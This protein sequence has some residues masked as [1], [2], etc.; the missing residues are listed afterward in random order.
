MTLT[1]ETQKP[2]NSRTKTHAQ[3]RTRAPLPLAMPER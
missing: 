2:R 3:T 1:E